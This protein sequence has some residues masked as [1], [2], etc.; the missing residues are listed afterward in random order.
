M[1]EDSLPPLRAVPPPPEPTEPSVSRPLFTVPSSETLRKSR[2]LLGSIRSG[3]VPAPARRNPLTASEGPGAVPPVPTLPIAGPTEPS[4]PQFDGTA[5]VRVV[6]GSSE[7]DS[8]SGV[9]T[10]PNFVQPPDSFDGELP[11]DIEVTAGKKK[12][13]VQKPKKIQRFRLS[14][15]NILKRNYKKG[16]EK[17][18]NAGCRLIEFYDPELERF[19]ADDYFMPIALVGGKTEEP[20]EQPA[21]SGLLARKL[22]DIQPTL[23]YAWGDAGELPPNFH[24]RMDNGPFVERSAP[25]TVMQW[26]P[27][28]LWYHPLYFEDVGLERYGHTRKPWIQPFVSSTKFFGQAIGMPYQ[29]VLHP[30]KSREFALGYYQPGEWAPKKRYQIPFNEEAAA[31]EFLWVTGVLLLIP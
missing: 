26:A 19:D 21:G 23:S 31:T 4:R 2:E 25:R 1:A 29:M 3:R 28:N 20:A 22:S 17:I 27:T 13:K 8:L 14:D 6:S 5:T 15:G 30:P 10:I 11:S 7:N 18:K 9:V 16:T 12:Q 24:D